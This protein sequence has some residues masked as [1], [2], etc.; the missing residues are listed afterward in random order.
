[1]KSDFL[2]IPFFEMVQFIHLDNHLDGTWCTFWTKSQKQY[3]L[4]LQMKAYLQK[5][6][7]SMQWNFWLNLEFLVNM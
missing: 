7:N 2:I 6:S 1:M 4:G 5:E 3:L